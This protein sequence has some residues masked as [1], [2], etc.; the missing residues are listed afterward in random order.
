MITAFSTASV[1]ITILFAIAIVIIFICQ[2]VI[3]F[4]IERSTL[5]VR[6]SRMR[7]KMERHSR[8]GDLMK[9]AGR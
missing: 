8:R 4:R 7:H 1:V 9:H 6:R 3:Y 2:W 5:E